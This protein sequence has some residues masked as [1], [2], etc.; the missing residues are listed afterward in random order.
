MRCR[1]YIALIAFL[2]CILRPVP[3]L[4]DEPNAA[5]IVD[6]QAAFLIKFSNY[7]KWP[8]T[9]FTDADDPIVIGIYGR[10]PFGSALDYLARTSQMDGRPI[11]V[12]RYGE[13]DDL[14]ECHI[15]FVAPGK[16]E[17]MPD[18]LKRLQGKPVCL[19]GNAPGVLEHSGVINFI[20]QNNKVRFDIS[21]SN[22]EKAGLQ[23]SSKLLK[24]AHEVR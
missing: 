1:F 22:A 10:D 19:V 9:A 20:E 11:V 15:L 16:M 14:S 17:N 24:V 23:I 13:N 8:D 12:S 18:I 3:G 4:V 6:I 7:I 2:C 5:R 21:R